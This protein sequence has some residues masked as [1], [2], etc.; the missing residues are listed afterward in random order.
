[1]ICSSDIYQPGFSV[2]AMTIHVS[3]N[4]GTQQQICGLAFAGNPGVTGMSENVE[5]WK[6]STPKTLVAP[7]EPHPKDVR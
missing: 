2:S 3:R 4:C 5:D 6:A 7:V 1:V